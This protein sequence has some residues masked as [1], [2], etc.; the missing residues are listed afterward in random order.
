M[1]HARLPARAR[2]HLRRTGAGIG[3]GVLALT[4]LPAATA[5]SAP[6]VAVST[7][8][9]A[10]DDSAV[11]ALVKPTRELSRLVAGF[12]PAGCT[13]RDR[14]VT[15]EETRLTAVL[16]AAWDP[17]RPAARTWARTM[18]EGGG[19]GGWTRSFATGLCRADSLE[20]ATAYV[21]KRG[22]ALWDRAVARAQEKGK[23]RGR[24]PASDDRPLYWVRTEAKAVLR[25]WDPGFRLG[26]RKRADLVD[27]FDKAAR[28]MLDIDF[29]VGKKVKRTLV[30]GFDPYTLDGGTTGPAAGTVGNNIRHGNPSG[31]TALALD[32]T[33]HRAKGGKVTSIEAYTLPV[34]YPEFERGYLEDT[35]GP[36]MRPGKRR[37]DASITVS[38]A[39]GSQFNLEQWNSRYHGLSL[40]NDRYAGCQR[41]GDR[42]QLAVDNPEC[43]TRVVKRWGGGR[44][45]HD[46]PQWTSASLPIGRMINADTGASVPRPEGSTWPD[47]SVAFGVVWNTNYSYFPRCTDAATVA[48]DQRQVTY[49]PTAEPT[50]PPA[51]SCAFSGAGGTYLSNESAYRNTLLR[52]RLGLKIPAGHIHTPDMQHFRSDFAPSDDLFDQWRNAI[53]DQTRRLVHVVARTS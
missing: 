50:P 24:L 14:R 47:P 20:D 27:A 40:G 9:R 29:P 53:V 13:D 35:V 52:D 25:Q 21:E 32:G 36:F 39:G 28:G 6:P 12:A 2:T 48:V 31:A 38:Q 7:A 34:S 37:L 11:T 26:G 49:P 43:N 10:A 16:P 42:L 8:T 33:R 22:G 19:F 45:L 46:P 15:P 41:V 3:A 44:T 18:V 1:L 30:S 4:L 23:V 5:A 17:S 51:G